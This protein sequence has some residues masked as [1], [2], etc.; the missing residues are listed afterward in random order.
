MTAYYWSLLEFCRDRYLRFLLPFLVA[1]FVLV[2]I[3]MV[4]G[5]NV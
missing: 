4:V 3:A 5:A 1:V 2:S